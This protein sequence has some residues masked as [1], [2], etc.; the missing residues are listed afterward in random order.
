MQARERFRCAVYLK[1][2]DCGHITM[3]ILYAWLGLTP[4]DSVG[5]IPLISVSIIHSSIFLPIS[6]YPCDFK[7]NA[8]KRYFTCGMLACANYFFNL[9]IWFYRY[10]PFRERKPFPFFTT[11]S[12]FHEKLTFF[13]CV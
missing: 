12:F 11:L 3:L 9:L 13:Q 2:K 10:C 7:G 4:K 1:G 6:I 8:A 5:S